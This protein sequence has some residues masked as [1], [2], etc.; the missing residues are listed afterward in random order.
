MSDR[1]RLVITRTVTESLEAGD[2]PAP[3]DSFVLYTSDG[4]IKV[5]LPSFGRGQVK[6]GITAPKAVKIVRSEII[7][8]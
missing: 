5:D 6:V 3:L 4:E 2:N 1:T 7:G 8:S